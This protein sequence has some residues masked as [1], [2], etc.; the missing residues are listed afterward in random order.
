MPRI[1]LKSVTLNFELS[2]VADAKVLML[3]N[4]LGTDLRMWDPQIDL[5]EKSY[6][7]LRYD[8]RGHGSSSV[9]AGP[10][11]MK[12]LG[13]DVLDLLDALHIE[14]VHFCGLSVGG[15]IGQWLGIN[16]DERLDRLILANTAAKI[17]TAD[18]WNTRIV[19][20]TKGGMKTIADA[21]MQRW[22]T[23]KLLSSNDP[24]VLQL[25]KTFLAV[26]PKGYIA[27]CA[28]IRD[29]D[30]RDLMGAIKVPVCI[31]AGELDPVTT[32]VDALLLQEHIRGAE[33]KVLPVA[34]ISNVEVP[35]A[36]NTTCLDFL[37]KDGD[38]E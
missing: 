3:S 5:F 17:G 16:A 31:I 28:A 4:S 36:F 2:G 8:M 35:E 22:F 34:H 7:V 1:D 32:V 21:V 33:L 25:K 13:N 29:M 11:T 23:P 27:S 24:R 30:F 19:D 6:R 15:M 14:R 37:S 26:D 10:Y 9:P 18:S 12:D 20:V 38:H